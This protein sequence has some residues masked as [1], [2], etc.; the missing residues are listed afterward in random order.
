MIKT[1][2]AFLALISLV[3][4]GIYS[5]LIDIEEGSK[6]VVIRSDEPVRELDPGLRFHIPLIERVLII[7][8]ER[9]Q[10]F[11]RSIGTTL[12]NGSPCM[13]EIEAYYGIHDATLAARL[14]DFEGID[15]LEPKEIEAALREEVALMAAAVDPSS[16]DAGFRQSFETELRNALSDNYPDGTA[17]RGLR[18][19]SMSCF[20]FAAAEKEAKALEPVFR[21]GDPQS[22]EKLENCGDPESAPFSMQLE[23]IPS[24]PVSDGNV[25]I[26]NLDIRY[27]F[28]P[29]RTRSSDHERQANRM[30]HRVLLST[31]TEIEIDELKDVNICALVLGQS[32]TTREIRNS[33]IEFLFL[34]AETLEFAVYEQVD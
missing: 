24:I 23:R 18:L 10:V 20:N 2:S 12:S 19:K 28:D 16:F 8:T 31:L 9:V 25:A 34:N 27:R 7:P 21:L 22:F 4:V 1:I 5:A 26:L 17:L 33:G 32:E 14:T 6:G 29:N 3:T 13:F 15:A 30:L 11:T